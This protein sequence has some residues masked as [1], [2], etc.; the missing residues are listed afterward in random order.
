MSGLCHIISVLLAYSQLSANLIRFYSKRF[1]A[2]LFRLISWLFHFV[3]HPND[4]F[5]SLFASAQVSA[6]P[7]LL[8]SVPYR[9]RSNPIYSFSFRLFSIPFRISSYRVASDPFLSDS[10]LF[11]NTL[12]CHNY[13]IGTPSLQEIRFQT[14]ARDRRTGIYFLPY[15]NSTVIAALRLLSSL[16][17][18]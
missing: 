7:S 16:A 15:Q 8:L 1:L 9:L 17:P 10:F 18:I 2:Y 12:S 4:S 3:S 5:P 14:L 13:C 11:Q 6:V